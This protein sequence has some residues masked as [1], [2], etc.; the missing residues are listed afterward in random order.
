MLS[1]LALF[2][3]VVG[4][5]LLGALATG[6]SGDAGPGT[7]FYILGV[8]TVLFFVSGLVLTFASSSFRTS[9]GGKV[10]LGVFV[11][12]IAFLGVC[13]VILQL[14]HRFSRG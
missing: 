4:G 3:F 11:G 7:A 2:V 13:V 9:T 14:V 8:C 12:V 5:S 1:R 10:A 6:F